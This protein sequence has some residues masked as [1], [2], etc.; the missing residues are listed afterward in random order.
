VGTSPIP[1]PSAWTVLRLCVATILVLAPFG[2]GSVAAGAGP[3]PGL[4]DTGLLPFPSPPTGLVQTGATTTSVTVAWDPPRDLV[5]GYD[6]YRDGIWYSSVSSTSATVSGLACERR[7]TIGVAAYDP[8]HLLHSDVSTVS[9]STGTCPPPTP[10]DLIEVE[11][12]QTSVTISWSESVGDVAGYDVFRD[13]QLAVTVEAPTATLIDLACGTSY[14]IGVQAFSTGHALSSGVATILAS[15]T[16]CTPD[17]LPPSAPGAPALT[18]VT[19]RSA[20][21][22]WPASSDDVGVA[23]YGLYRNGELVATTSAG[24]Y[25]FSALLCGVTYTLGVDAYDAAG[26]RSAV[27]GVEVT[28]DVCPPAGSADL[29]VS[30]LGSDANDCRAATP[31]LSLDRAYDVALPGAVVEV[32]GG[33]YGDQVLS[34]TKTAPGV[35]IRPATGERVVLGDITISA[36]RVELR[37]LASRGGLE[38]FGASD[39]ATARNLDLTGKIYVAGARD[40]SIIGGDVGP[41]PDAPAWVTHDGN[42]VPERLLIEGVRFHDFTASSEIVHTECLLV[43]AGDGLVFRGNTWTNCAVFDLSF[44]YCCE[45]PRPPTNVLIENNFFGPSVSGGAYTLHFNTNL[46]AANFTIRN[47]SAGGPIL[48]DQS[49]AVF[50]NVNAV[51]NALPSSGCGRATWTYNVFTGSACP[52]IANKVVSSHGFVDPAGGDFHITADS[53]LRDAGSPTDFAPLD[54]DGELRPFGDAPD[55]GADEFVP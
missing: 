29:F 4:E 39:F 9:A 47:N 48:L 25:T 1:H 53:P 35:L 27:V 41:S 19:D 30:P 33:L 7:Y 12:T 21:I 54:F 28:T 17:T 13:G 36:D 3:A 14:A 23:G 50:L 11:A 38:V 24:S 26:N 16:A 51:G 18:G 2:P 10:T 46:P 20:S 8:L 34:G 5:G 6:V 49:Q 31:C 43:I 22:A 37:D 55:S 32:A 15:T 45:S 40:L 44:G 42:L 52:G